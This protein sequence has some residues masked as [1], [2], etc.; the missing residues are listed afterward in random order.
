[1]LVERSRRVLELVFLPNHSGR[2]RSFEVDRSEVA[3]VRRRARIDGWRFAGLFHSHPVSEAVPSKRDLA[4]APGNS[5]MLIYDVCAPQA[6]LWRVVRRHSRTY[7]N[8]QE[9]VTVRA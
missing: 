6:R 7:A 3:R 9:L 8:E 5:L 1:V 2:P 4:E